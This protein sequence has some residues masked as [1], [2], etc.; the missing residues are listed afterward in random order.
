MITLLSNAI[1]ALSVGVFDIDYTTTAIPF[2]ALVYTPQ[3]AYATYES[4]IEVDPTD[5]LYLYSSE[6]YGSGGI[7]VSF[8]TTLG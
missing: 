8:Y 6:R 4:T 7:T 5:K 2:S 3:W 1:V